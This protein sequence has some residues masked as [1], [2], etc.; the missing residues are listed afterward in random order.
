MDYVNIKKLKFFDVSFEIIY[1]GFMK[2]LLKITS[3]FATLLL[4]VFL[5]S[6]TTTGEY[7]PLSNNEIV[8]GTIQVTF[9][10]N[11][12]APSMK[13]VRNSINTEA[14][15]K[16]LEAAERKYSGNVDIRDIVWVTRHDYKKPTVSEIFATGKVIRT[17]SK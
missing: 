9:M 17:D 4:T 15:I 11:S 3:V 12:S 1:G 14:Y 2:T 10:V 8:I 7:M 13:R 16:L 6:C 5:F